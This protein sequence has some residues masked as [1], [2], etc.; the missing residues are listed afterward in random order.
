MLALAAAALVAVVLAAPPAASGSRFLQLGIFDDTQILHGATDRVY[1]EL[2]GLGVQVVRVNLW[3]GGPAGMGVARRKPLNPMNPNDPAYDWSVYDRAVQYAAQYGMKVVFS[4]LGTPPWANAGKGWNVAPTS[5]LD[6]KR[7]A[8]AAAR[9]YRGG[10]AGADGRPLASVQ[11]WLVWNEPNNPVFLKPQFKRVGGK[12]T[13]QS[14]KDYAKLCN[15]AVDAIKLVTIGGAKVACG[16]T[17][18]RGNNNP[19]EARASVS[20]LAFLRAMK[21]AGARG[22]DAYAHHP[23]YGSPAESPLTPPPP[24]RR[25]NAP[26]A[27]TLGNFPLLVREVTRLYGNKRIWITEYGYQTNPPD[28]AFGVSYTRQALYLRQ[29]YGYARRHPRI[30][31][32]L[33]F[34]LRD[35]ARLDRWQSGL[36][37]VA[38]RRKP[39]YATFANLRG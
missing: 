36:M 31:M 2:N 37:T 11:N 15:A 39:A 32:F 3:W 26:T 20:P 13:I 33:W 18:P 9:R 12:W 17:G 29:A 24:G 19:S 35:E 7:F 5:A 22:F 27:I 14:A 23:Y 25:G 21:S 6:F 16:V 10:F 30:D 1:R 38:G 8:T 28:R 34:L 4:L